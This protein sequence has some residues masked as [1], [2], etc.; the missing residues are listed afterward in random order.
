MIK[1]IWDQG[2]KKTYKKKIKNNEALKEHFWAAIEKFSINPFDQ[3]LRAH[4]LTGKLAG[5]W[6]F[7]VEY[8]CRVVFRF[9]DKNEVL[10]IDIGTHD[11]VY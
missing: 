4:K 5:L 7:S 8:D 1:L 6:A 10:L 2:F 9:L 11:E 3:G